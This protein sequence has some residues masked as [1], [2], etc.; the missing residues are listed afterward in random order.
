VDQQLDMFAH[1]AA[2][3]LAAPSPLPKR[4]RRK[5]ERRRSQLGWRWAPLPIALPQTI[6]ECT[7][8]GYRYPHGK[9]PVW[10]CTANVVL[11]R[12]RSATTETLLVGGR[13]GTGK[14]VSLPSKRTPGG[15][16][17]ELLIDALWTAAEDRE[18]ELPSTCLWDYTADNDLAP[19]RSSR[20]LRDGIEDRA[21]M[22]LEQIGNVLG[23]TKEA[24]RRLEASAL[25]K[26]KAVGI[27][28]R[29]FVPVERL[30]RS[31]SA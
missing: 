23:V 9:C 27:E 28:M 11:E 20:P 7:A 2:V 5:V 4:K 18:D 14:G 26:L 8:L 6:D 25:R 1:V 17:T 30:K 19:R 16:V 10:H 31:K 24:A 22:T 29:G 21:H 12:R 13:G 3:E 15:K